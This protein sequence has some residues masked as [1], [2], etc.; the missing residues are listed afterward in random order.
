M[1]T[2]LNLQDWIPD[3]LA[4]Q[5]NLR[6][7]ACREPRNAFEA[8]GETASPVSPLAYVTE[9]LGALKALGANLLYLMPPYPMGL[10]DR[11][12]I[13]S[14][15]SARDFRDVDPEYGTL[16]ELA[17]FVR[18]A[19]DLGFKVIFDITPNHT[20]RDNVWA[21]SHPEYYVK[22][23]DGELYFDGDWSDTAKL[24][25]SHAGL[26]QAMTDVYDH[27]LSFLGDDRGDGVDGFRFD[28]AHF[29]ND[30]SFWDEALPALRAQHAGRELLFLA[31]CYGTANNMALFERGMGAAYDDDFYK[32]CQYGY[33]RDVNGESCIALADDAYHNDD[34]ADKLSAFESGG[35]A[36]AV[37]CALVNY[38]PSEPNTA[39]TR[40]PSL[41]RYT[42]NHDE[43]RGV[44]RFGP[45]AVRAINQLIFMAPDTIPMLLT[46]QEFGAENRPPIHE[47]IG[48]CD[49]GYRRVQEGRT[50]WCDGIE[51]E[52]NCFARGVDARQAWYAFYKELFALRTQHEALRRGSFALLDAAEA[53][54]SPDRCV[55]AFA[56]QH[57]G[58]TL[59]CAVN[60]GPDARTL[61]NA[62]LSQGEVLY[63]GLKDHSLP[64][65]AAIVTRMCR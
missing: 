55:V 64:A 23:D 49:K 3:A 7:L 24:D 41:L 35:I 60:L 32:I 9:N 61:G 31:E 53:C 6:S 15:Y 56:R 62:E 26:R 36:G 20:S 54:A 18:T 39:T 19:H 51:F 11:K 21:T 46:G 34:F 63:G 45:G 57:D 42:D 1:S 37:E 25:Y 5:I 65:F 52:G 16:D 29:I 17:T 14:P 30:L 38:T 48:L 4:Y 10:T 27:W 12:G 2:E 28:M 22:A 58:T 44:Y 13:G 33:A 59:H 40:R 50:D 8:I 47:R 43:G